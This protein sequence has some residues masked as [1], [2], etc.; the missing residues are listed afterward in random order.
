MVNKI[1]LTVI[2]IMSILSLAMFISTSSFHPVEEI[3]PSTEEAAVGK[4][5]RYYQGS[6]V[7]A[8]GISVIT[9]PR[10][11]L[12]PLAISH[13]KEA[14]ET[15]SIV[16]LAV[17]SSGGIENGVYPTCPFIEAEDT[18][19][20]IWYT[21]NMKY[22]SEEVSCLDY[23]YTREDLEWMAK[24]IHCEICDQGAEARRAVGTVIMNRIEWDECPDTVLG[25]I[26][27]ENQFSP[28]GNGSIFDAEPCEYC[29]EAAYDVLENHYRSFPKEVRYFQSISDGYFKGF[30]TYAYFT[31][32][33]FDTWF[34]FD[35]V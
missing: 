26:S 24:I 27:Q 17:K 4:Y 30:L 18:D 12:D 11:D 34:C 29:I 10:R 22:C 16:P 19:R 1:A 28:W 35:P 6:K 7:S 31:E 14:P 23:K 5:S 33:G 3:V 9:E 21:G 13:Y 15:T 2:S 8:D 20:V 32:A 25:V